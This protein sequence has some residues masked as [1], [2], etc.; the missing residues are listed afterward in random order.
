MLVTRTHMDNFDTCIFFFVVCFT[1]LTL[2]C[3]SLFH[4]AAALISCSF[5]IQQFVA[6]AQPSKDCA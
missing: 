3:T 2:Q 4:Y 6:I 5:I 1:T